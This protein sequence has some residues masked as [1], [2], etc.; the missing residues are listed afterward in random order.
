MTVSELI[1]KL[2]VLPP[3]LP[4][5]VNGYEDG[6]C[7]PEEPREARVALDYDTQH[8][9]RGPHEEVRGSYDE[10]RVR[11]RECPIVRAVIIPR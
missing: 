11:E 5:F 8:D 3:E 4:V 10:D 6:V 9:W 1:Q 2:S 7:D